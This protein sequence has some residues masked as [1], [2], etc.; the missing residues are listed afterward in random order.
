MDLSLEII[1]TQFRISKV[2]MN[3]EF[4]PIQWLS[5]IM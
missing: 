4:K 3:V 5:I 2:F 1:D